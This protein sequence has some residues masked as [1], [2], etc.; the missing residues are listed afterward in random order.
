M[1]A[2]VLGTRCISL[3][4]E[5]TLVE[6]AVSD[7]FASTQRRQ[8]LTS[9]IEELNRQ[10]ESVLLERLSSVPFSS[11]VEC[12]ENFD[13]RRKSYLERAL[14]R[15]V[16]DG[17]ARPSLEYLS[18]I[19]KISRPSTCN[20]EVSHGEVLLKKVTKLLNDPFLSRKRKDNV[21]QRLDLLLENVKCAINS[22]D[23]IDSIQTLKLAIHDPNL[24]ECVRQ[25]ILQEMGVVYDEAVSKSKTSKKK[26]RDRLALSPEQTLRFEGT[27]LSFLDGYGV[28]E[29]DYVRCICVWSS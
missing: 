16:D 2:E 5:V 15:L 27:N 19:Q 11:L 4:Q 3:L 12:L 20:L 23:V 14:W 7:P 17:R 29:P 26:L 28:S 13:F 21:R 1:E 25:R 10:I 18:A 9:R 8:Q 24:E 6:D 22:D